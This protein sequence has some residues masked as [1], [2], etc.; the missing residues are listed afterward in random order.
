MSIAADDMIASR[1]A[2]MQRPTA[3]ARRYA[4]GFCFVQRRRPGG[5]GGRVGV[6]VQRKEH[7]SQKVR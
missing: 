7:G 1:P 5:P 4:L 6:A 2:C 3:L